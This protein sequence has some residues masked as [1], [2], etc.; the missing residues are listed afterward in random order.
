VGKQTRSCYEIGE[1]S[2]AWIKYKCDNEQEFVIGGYT[3][4]EKTNQLFRSLIV[5][6]YEGGQLKYASKGGNR[7]QRPT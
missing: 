3:L 7:L 4:S 6:Y 5:G 1:R 2:G